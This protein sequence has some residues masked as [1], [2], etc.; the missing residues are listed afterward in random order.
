MNNE[1]GKP[2][3]IPHAYTPREAANIRNFAEISYG[4]Y[5]EESK[6][7]I[8]DMFIG[9]FFMQYKTFMVGRFEQ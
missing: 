3:K 9:A 1:N 7:I 6:A 5:D 2:D 4:H 8:N